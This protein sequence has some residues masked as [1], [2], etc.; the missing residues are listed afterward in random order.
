MGENEVAMI[1]GAP[2]G[3]G[4]EVALE[5]AKQGCRL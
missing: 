1:T 3:I 5:L 4:K 2:S